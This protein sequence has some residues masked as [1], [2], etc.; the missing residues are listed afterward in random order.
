MATIVDYASLNQALQDWLARSDI[1]A[2]PDYF[3]QIAENRIYRDILNQ[4]EGRGVRQMEAALSGTI[5]SNAIA[6]PSDYL[7]LKAARIVVNSEWYPLERK[8]AEFIY[9]NYPAQ[10]STG[11]PSF[12]ADENGNFIFGPY[13]DSAYTVNG[14]Y[15]KKAAALSSTN[16]TTWMITAIPDVLFASCMAAAAQFVRDD[17]TRDLWNAFYQQGLEAFIAADKASAWSGS[18]LAITAA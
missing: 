18:S 8:N 7:A 9:G 1:A 12:I 5:A 3:I 11:A 2:Y 15:W 14:V 16:T 10:T 13:A 17:A 6:I 4:N